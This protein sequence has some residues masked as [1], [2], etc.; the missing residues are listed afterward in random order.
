MPRSRSSSRSSSSSEDIN[1]AVRPRHSNISGHGCHCTVTHQ[2]SSAIIKNI[3]LEATVDLSVLEKIK[4]DIPIKTQCS[5]KNLSTHSKPTVTGPTVEQ[6]IKVP[7][8]QKQNSQPQKNLSQKPKIEQLAPEENAA[9]PPAHIKPEPAQKEVFKIIIEVNDLPKMDL[10]G[11]ADP[12]FYFYLDNKLYFGGPDKAIKNSRKGQWSFPILASLVRNSNKITIKW[13]DYDTVGKDDE[14][15]TTEVETSKAI[16]H[17]VTGSSNKSV[18]NFLSIKGKN[19]D[20]S[21][22]SVSVI[23]E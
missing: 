1:I 14:I 13:F 16:R 9:K 5:V 11:G 3:V 2:E 8:T 17:I 22:V 15:G 4:I 20:K 19:C 12:Y 18:T 7:Q 21:S 23:K 10:V 6:Q